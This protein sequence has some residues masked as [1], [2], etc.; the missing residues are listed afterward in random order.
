M[1]LMC[2][3]NDSHDVWF[4]RYGAWQTEFFVILDH[5]LYF[6]PPNILESQNFEKM[7]KTL[8]DIVILHMCTIN[9]NHLVY[10]S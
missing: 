7:K 2:A 3:I 9:D 8:G 4:L 5:F 10:V 1:L 6:Y